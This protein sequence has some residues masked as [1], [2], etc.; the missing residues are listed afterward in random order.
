MR[1]SGVTDCLGHV[2]MLTLVFEQL[3]KLRPALVIGVTAV[4]IAKYIV[5]AIQCFNMK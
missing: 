4:L 3:A 2:A 5:H 1:L